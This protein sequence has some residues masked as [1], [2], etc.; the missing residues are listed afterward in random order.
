MPRFRSPNSRLARQHVGD[1]LAAARAHRL[2]SQ[3]AK[4]RRDPVALDQIKHDRLRNPLARPAFEDDRQPEFEHLAQRV[5]IT[6]FLSK[7]EVWHGSSTVGAPRRLP[8]RG[9]D[10][11]PG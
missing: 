10:T 6:I 8:H 9:G 4:R 7:R 1:A 2:L 5:P 11:L 3:L